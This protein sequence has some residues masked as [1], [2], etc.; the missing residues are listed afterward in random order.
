MFIADAHCDTLFSIGVHGEN[1]Q[2]CAVTAERM[3]KAGVGLQTF[4]M[5]AGGEG[6]KGTP[7]LF[8]K[9]MM[10]AI[11]K[12][13]V[14]VFRGDLPEGT[15]EAPA[16][17]ISIEGG[18]ILE[19]KMERLD[20]FDSEARVRLIALTWNNE[21]EIGHPAKEGP[22]GHLKPFGIE[23]LREMD[24]RG[25]YADVS[26]LNEAGFWDIC[27]KAV[28]PPVASHSNARW[29]CEHTRNLKKEQV[30]A[31]IEKKGFIG[32]NFYTAFLTKEE[33][34]T[35]DDVLRHIDAICE[36]GGEDI[37]GFGSDFDGIE[38]WP[39]GLANPADFVNLTDALKNH[40]YTDKQIEKFARMNY[41]NLLRNGE[42]IRKNNSNL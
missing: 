39:V 21:N 41:L 38:K 2:N 26:H 12:L 24:R 32:I 19:G 29:E 14:T 34:A 17:V 30:K 18:E 4:A 8:G 5:F 31:I 20:E 23:L 3:K 15:P 40:G 37:L 9:K 11:D 7:Y 35:I 10:A 16:G 6:P 22:E 33:E 13:G 36:L 1:T 25:I 27:E 28:L 42:K